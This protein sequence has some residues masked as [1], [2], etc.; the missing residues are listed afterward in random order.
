MHAIA[1]G[2]RRSLPHTHAPH[3]GFVAIENLSSPRAGSRQ[4]QHELRPRGWPNEVAARNVVDLSAPRGS[5]VSAHTTESSVQNPDNP[6][7]FF[8]YA[9]SRRTTA[10]VYASG[11]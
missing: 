2:T 10:V 4:Q 7:M 1:F 5:D 3:Q 8:K 6:G 9:V 11:V